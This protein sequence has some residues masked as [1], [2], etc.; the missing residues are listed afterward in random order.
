M[1][2]SI[3]DQHLFLDFA[4][5]YD[6]AKVRELI[7]KDIAYVNAQPSGRWTALHQACHQ[8]DSSTVEFLLGK[9]ADTKVTTQAGETPRAVAEG[10]GHTACVKLLDDHHTAANGSPSKKGKG[11]SKAAS[12][13]AGAPAP[14]SQKVS[15]K[16]GVAQVKFDA[17][18][19][20]ATGKQVVKGQAGVDASCP[21]AADVHVYE[22]DDDDVY[23][24]LLN[25]T[26]I[27]TNANKYYIIQLLETDDASK[28]YYTWN[29]SRP[30]R[31]L[32]AVCPGLI[33]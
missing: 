29:R 2:P 6:F 25:Q 22:A 14:K 28:N 10:R 13:A 33:G 20:A 21:I 32:L 23:D 26:D 19:A 5:K 1:P 17:S 31:V 18:G 15:Q 27:A 11:K 8:G 12:S 24:A 4:K 7:E 9:G 30:P 16:K 3:A